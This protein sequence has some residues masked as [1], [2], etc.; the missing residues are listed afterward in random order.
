MDKFVRKTTAQSYSRDER[1]LLNSW[2][3]SALQKILKLHSPSIFES[4][5]KI[6]MAHFPINLDPK[7]NASLKMA[8]EEGCLPS[9]AAELVDHEGHPGF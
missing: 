1:V 3:I 2:P 8:G 4:S 7:P 9:A 6:H 5:F